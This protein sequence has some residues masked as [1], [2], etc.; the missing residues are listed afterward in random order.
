[1]SSVRE[2]ILQAIAAAL[3]RHISPERFARIALTALR[4]TKNLDKCD[5]SSV[6]GSLMTCA[7]LGLRPCGRDPRR[8]IP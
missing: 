3:P 1:M 6:L 8:A 5:S 7:Q 2:T 4:T